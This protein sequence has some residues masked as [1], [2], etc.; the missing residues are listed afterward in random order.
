MEKAHN[1]KSSNKDI[2]LQIVGMS[3]V[4]CAAKIEKSLNELPGVEA[5]V[6]FVSEKAHVKVSSQADYEIPF[7]IERVNKLG[8]K[9]FHLDSVHGEENF[10]QEQAKDY[11]L[12]KKIFAFSAVFA[13]PFMIEMIMMLLNPT[14]SGH[15][16]IV[17]RMWQFLLATPV[18]VIAGYRFYKGAYYALK[19]KA[20]NMDVLVA[21]GTSMAYLFSVYV[22]FSDRHDLHVYFEASVMILAFIL[23]GKLLEA[24]AKHK[25][26]SAVAQLLNLQPAKAIVLRDGKEVE[27]AVSEIKENDIAI[28]KVGEKIPV[29]GLVESGE[30]SVAESMLTGESIPVQ[31]IKGAKVFAGTTVE[32]G[33][34]QV[35]ALSV[36]Q[37]TQLAQII[38]IVSAAQNSKADLQKMADQ[39]SKYFVPIVLV[40]SVLSF[41]GNYLW[42]GDLSTALIRAVA[43]LVIA[44]PCALGLAT[45][46]AISVGIGKAARRGVLFKDANAL[47][48]A[49][50]LTQVFLDKTGTITLGHPQITEIV[51][52][53]GG[54]DL[55]ALRVAALLEKGSTHPLAKAIVNKAETAGVKFSADITQHSTIAGEGISANIDGKK[56]RIGKL[57]DIDSKL[58]NFQEARNQGQALEDK[59][60]SVIYLVDGS[61]VLALFAL[62]DEVRPEAKVVLEQLRARKI[63]LKL[64]TGDNS[65]TAH[66]VADKVGIADVMAEVRPQEKANQIV[67]AQRKKQI[68]GMVGDGINDAP[69]LALADVSFSMGE[70]TGVAI[71]AADVTLVKGDLTGLLDTIR[72]SEMTVGKIKQNLFFAF[73]Y[74]CLGIPLAAVG[75]L[76]PVIAGAAMALSSVSV[77]TNSLLLKNKSLD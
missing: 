9:A 53:G 76:N 71:E 70:G 69:A 47:E 60:Y 54:S 74:N 55:E 15:D 29:D 57:T 77:L 8:Y 13:I 63:H 4:N 31:K 21:L 52:F 48:A 45:P 22:T 11:S 40:I 19:N 3:C 26:S 1:E 36:G 2:E 49:S 65:K 58:L 23:L 68:V 20:A 42:L 18:Q 46:T 17:P 66:A 30:A 14:T 10:K 59:S 34:I 6:Q 7:L 67:I 61:Q 5:E 73:I 75:L 72:I 51:S 27:I 37:K 16:H 39:I 12:L 50:K 44:C 62:I 38:K 24:R 41:F 28:V 43:V 33:L 56:Y 25:T 32:N 35:R 64:L